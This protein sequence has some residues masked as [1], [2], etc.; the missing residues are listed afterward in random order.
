M[1]KSCHSEII[2]KNC[3]FLHVAPPKD[4]QIAKE[5]YDIFDRNLDLLTH[6]FLNFFG[7]SNGSEWQNFY[8]LQDMPMCE[9]PSQGSLKE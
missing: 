3:I 2:L 9:I 4:M 1:L 6:A 5:L 8:I 7:I